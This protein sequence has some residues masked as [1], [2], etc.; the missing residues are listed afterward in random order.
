LSESSLNVMV[1]EYSILS[2]TTASLTAGG[3]MGK[4]SG[5]YSIGGDPTGGKEA[6]P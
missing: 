6:R 1:L 4:I 2:Y 3:G 5:S